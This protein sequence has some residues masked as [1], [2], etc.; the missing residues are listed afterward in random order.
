VLKESF[1]IFKNKS[2]HFLGIGDLN[3]TIS[4]ILSTEITETVTKKAFADKVFKKSNGTGLHIEWE[5]D[6]SNADFIRFAEY[7]LGLT[8]LHNILFQTVILSNKKP[9]NIMWESPSMLF[10]PTVI[11]L[12]D[13]NFD[14]TIINIDYMIENNEPINELELIYLPMYSSKAGKTDYERLKT[15]I[16]LTKTTIEDE[17]KRKK[18]NILIIFLNE[19]FVGK[20]VARK[21][22]EDMKLYEDNV[23][24][25]IGEEKGIEKGIEKVLKKVLRE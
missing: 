11:I 23:F 4:D 21:V 5:A 1:D 8:K 18:I 15:A 12:S 16:E 24:V 19:R 25:Q 22:V 7:H 13:R 9:T 3:D 14:K 20:D 2:L 10:K 6:I 17:A